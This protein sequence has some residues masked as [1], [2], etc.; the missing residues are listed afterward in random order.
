MLKNTILSERIF[1]IMK[2]VRLLIIK[3]KK[4]CSIIQANYCLIM[5]CCKRANYVCF[6][7]NKKRQKV[8]LNKV[9]GKN[10]AHSGRKLCTQSLHHMYSTVH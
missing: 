3:P 5:K 2:Q 7:Y 4:N 6:S 8:Q 10:N 9:K 1:K